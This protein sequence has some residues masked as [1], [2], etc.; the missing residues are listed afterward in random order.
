[1]QFVAL[2]E[3]AL[4]V[5]T[6]SPH[7]QQRR[8]GLR[9]PPDR[10]MEKF[11]GLHSTGDGK[12]P[13]SDPV[14]QIIAS[15]SKHHKESQSLLSLPVESRI[16]RTITDSERRRNGEGKHTVDESSRKKGS[17][18]GRETGGCPGPM[19]CSAVTICL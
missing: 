14:F 12:V 10:I 17:I 16:C 9:G 7:G 6:C 15:Y 4:Q 1:M 5:V 18:T 2:L 3:E 13:G 19:T 8:R 11:L